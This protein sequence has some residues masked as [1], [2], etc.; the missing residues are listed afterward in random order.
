M[1]KKPSTN[2]GPVLTCPDCGVDLKQSG[3]ITFSIIYPEYSQGH[4]EP[5]EEGEIVVLDLLSEEC[6]YDIFCN[7]CGKDLI[8]VV[9][10]IDI[11]PDAEVLDDEEDPDD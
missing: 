2:L 9:E 6:E 10:D 7:N 3:T 1:G 4:L 5:G 8:F 11:D